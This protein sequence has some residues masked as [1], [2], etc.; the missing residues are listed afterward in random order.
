MGNTRA[1]LVTAGVLLAA[2]IPLGPGGT[3]LADPLPAAGPARAA[4]EGKTAAV[5]PGRIV[6]E[7]GPLAVPAGEEGPVTTRLTVHLPPGTTGR[8][9]PR[10]LGFRGPFREEQGRPAQLFTSTCAVNGGPF[11]TCEW[12]SPDPDVIEETW[13]TLYLPDIQVPQGA[14]TVTYDITVDVPSN[15]LWLGRLAGILEL[16]DGS[17]L[18]ATGEVVF[19]LLP[20]TPE[21][22]DR[23]MLHARDRDGVLW[24]YEATGLARPLLKPRTRVGG[25][26][27]V[28]TALAKP[29]GGN[30][31]AF[32]RMVARDRAGILWIYE[33]TLH[34]SRP[35]A[36]RERVGGGWNVYTSIVGLANGG[37]VARDRA[38][39][40]WY[41]EGNGPSR[42]AFSPRVRVG[43]G[44]NVYTGITSYG[45]GLVARTADGRQW[46]YERTE[47]VRPP[48]PFT[49]RRLVGGGWNDFTL[50]AG[51][52]TV[53]QE[54]PSL[55]ARAKDGA[56]WMYGAAR[57]GDH[58]Q[59]TEPAHPR[60]VGGGW[61]VYD[62]IL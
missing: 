30:A 61:N 54:G 26:W 49:P 2:L 51:T 47:G 12:Q 16:G 32:G 11:E 1:L 59:Y 60:R 23:A 52:G 6:Q 38:G 10:S 44:W 9:R 62:L 37:L 42:P 53:G 46:R 48:V 35:F 5:E 19:Q 36:P 15:A 22:S 40:L 20:G 56:L 3:A 55:A 34:P 41:Y 24:Q 45:S 27:N 25:G 4:A 18:V 31:D 57:W 17:G 7:G 14:S 8:L 13:L 29:G 43:G 50:L 21:A 39:V 58:L 33:G 28:Y